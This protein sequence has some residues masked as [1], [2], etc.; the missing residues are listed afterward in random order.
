MTRPVPY[1]LAACCLGLLTAP[2]A[3]RDD[4]A[5]EVKKEKAVVEANLTMAGLGKLSQAETDDLLV[6][7]TVPEAKVKALGDGAQKSFRLACA[8]LKFGPDEKLWPGKLSLVVLTDPQQFTTYVRLVEQRRP[9]KGVYYSMDLRS[10]VPAVIDSVDAGEKATDAE[11]RADAATIVAAALL[12]KKAGT[13]T[14]L[15]EWLLLGFGRTIAV[16]SE[17]GP[18]LSA[19]RT[20]VKAAVLGSKAQPIPARVSDVWNGQKG[21]DSDLVSASLAEYLAFGPEAEKFPKL[22]SALKPSD[23]QP[24]P[25]V[26]TALTNLEWTSDALEIGWKQWVAKQK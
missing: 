19:Y 25:T 18:K 11:I 6:Y 26:A 5:A 23:T 9:D 1:L 12:A 2:L 3:A 10:D 7:A 22:L 21:K 14:P 16:R 13:G 17:G 4:R 8:T 15:P 24:M 20:K